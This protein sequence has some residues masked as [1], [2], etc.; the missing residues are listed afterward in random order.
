MKKVFLML[1]VFTVLSFSVNAQIDDAYGLP[2]TFFFSDNT[3]QKFARLEGF[4]GYLSGSKLKRSSE[5]K[6][7]VEREDEGKSFHFNYN[8]LRRSLFWTEIKSIEILDFK[9]TQNVKGY[10]NNMHS[11]TFQIKLKN[12]KSIVTDRPT[13]YAVAV[14][15]YIEDDLTGRSDILAKYYFDKD[16][17]VN[18]IVFD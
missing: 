7:F 11:I 9:R 17:F 8:K 14:S 13:E 1:I 4:Y 2:G 3:T 10:Y 6:Y 15:A 18:K 12:G 16:V 5:N